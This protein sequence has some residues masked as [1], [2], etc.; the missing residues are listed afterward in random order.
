MPVSPRL[1]LAVLLL[2][3]QSHAIDKASEEDLTVTIQNLG[4][5]VSPTEINPPPPPPGEDPTLILDRIINIG[6]KIWTIIEKN[7]PVVDVK[8]SYAVAVPEG[9]RTWGQLS[10]WKPPKGTVYAFKAVNT[11][12]VTVV[13]V[14]Y[15]VLRT[16]GGSYKEKGK[17]LTAVTIEP[18]K[19]EVAWGYKFSLFA[20]VPDSGIF[21]VGTTEDPVAGMIA[22]VRWQIETVMKNSSGKSVYYVEGTG[23]FE[24]VGGPFERAYTKKVENALEKALESL[25][26]G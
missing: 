11:Y 3:T 14:R 18:L 16:Y 6:Q 21:N 23:K 1:I 7:K 24:E 20:E 9:T 13:N 10:G 22:T 8:T 26:K 2:A 15:Q 17:Y 5:T 12:G 4:P 19:V 25:P